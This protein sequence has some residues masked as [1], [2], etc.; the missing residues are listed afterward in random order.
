MRLPGDGKNAHGRLPVL[1][2]LQGLRRALEAISG[3]LL[4]VLFLRIGAVPTDPGWQVVPSAV[5]VG[6]FAQDGPANPFYPV[7]YSSDLKVRC[8]TASG[9][10]AILRMLPQVCL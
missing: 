8:R 3:R 2:R 1:L 5:A 10:S 4:R 9:A 6:G 7:E